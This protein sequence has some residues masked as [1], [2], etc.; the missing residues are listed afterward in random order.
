M[1]PPRPPRLPQF[2]G[3]HGVTSNAPPTIL[4]SSTLSPRFVSSAVKPL[5]GSVSSQP[6]SQPPIRGCSLLV[7][8]G[9]KPLLFYFAVFVPPGPRAAWLVCSVSLS[10]FPLYL[11][12]LPP[13]ALTWVYGAKAGNL[14][15]R[16]FFFPIPILLPQGCHFLL[17]FPFQGCH[18]TGFK[19]S[20]PFSL[21]NSAPGQ[22]LL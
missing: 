6:L 19:Q 7:S 5:G 18:K 17:L 4:S 16:H 22:L 3:R 9:G 21:I 14:R 10:P 2:S 8:H 11:Q 15:R 13:Q 1:P 12:D 20:L